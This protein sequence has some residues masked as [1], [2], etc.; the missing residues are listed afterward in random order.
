MCITVFTKASPIISLNITYSTVVGHSSVN[1]INNISTRG[2]YLLSRVLLN[3][4]H[5]LRESVEHTKQKYDDK[6][7]IHLKEEKTT[8]TSNKFRK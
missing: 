1:L 6:M 8:T 2:I 5:Q 3:E 7:Y 4:V